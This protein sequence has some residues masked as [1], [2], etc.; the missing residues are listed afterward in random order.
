MN[1][2]L[3]PSSWKISILLMPRPKKNNV[4]FPV[5][6]AKNLGS[7]GRDFFFFFF[8][9]FFFMLSS[10]ML[11]FIKKQ[12]IIFDTACFIQGFSGVNTY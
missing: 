1:L 3:I 2:P 9:F 11:I 10:K 6:V 8:F 7:V 5:T 4:G 12:T